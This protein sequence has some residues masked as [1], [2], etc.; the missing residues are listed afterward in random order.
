M[1]S[2]AS[3]QVL[4]GT[5]GMLPFRIKICGITTIE[6]GLCSEQAGADAI[7]LNFVPS[8]LRY[9]STSAAK[10]IT[11][12]L[13][14][15]ILKVG[16]F[17]NSSVDSIL[18]VANQAGL[19]AI[20]L[21]GDEP[22]SL[23]SQLR[24]SLPQ[25]TPIIKAF[26]LQSGT[27]KPAMDFP[28]YCG[29]GNSLPDAILVDAYAPGAYGGTGHKLDWIGLA[30]QRHLVSLPVIVAGGLVPENVATAIAQSGCPAVDTASGVEST[31]PR[32]DPAKVLAFVSQ[33]KQALG[34]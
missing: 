11:S 24:K 10:E 18:Q 1:S 4:Q 31:A 34:L 26:R 28:A 19:T 2:Q 17:V 22:A 5:A 3:V 6:D 33:A 7:G 25:S 21:H 27:L 16:V 20:Q 12:A 30:E 23:V 9:V 32:K 8:S 13:G 29:S 15:G 14:N